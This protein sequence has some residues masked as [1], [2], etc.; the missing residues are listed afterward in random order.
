LAIICTLAIHT[1]GVARKGVR[2][3]VFVLVVT[4]T[5][6]VAANWVAGE[7]LGSKIV[8]AAMVVLYLMAEWVASQVK[9][10]AARTNTVVRQVQA[11][12]QTTGTEVTADDAMA[13]D[14]PEAPTSPGPQRYSERHERRLRTG[15]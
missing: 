6:S 11:V 12:E 5:G 14:L 8:H 3:A 9:V 1:E 13:D 2:T 7:T 10:S 4:G 15:R